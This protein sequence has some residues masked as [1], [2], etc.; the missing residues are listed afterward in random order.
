[1]DTA[2]CPP[3]RFSF[4][5]PLD[6]NIGDDSRQV[7]EIH[8]RR[9]IRGN[10]GSGRAHDSR[11]RARGARR[12]PGRLPRSGDGGRFPGSFVEESEGLVA[13]AR[14]ELREETGLADPAVHLE[15]LAT[16]GDPRRDPR[17][18][19]V[20]V[21]YLALAAELPDPLS[22]KRRV[23]SDL[24]TGCGATL[25]L[26]Q[27]CLRPRHNPC[28]RPRASPREA[29][30]LAVGD[31]VL[32]RRVHRRRAPSRVRGRLGHRARSAQLS[33]K[34]H[35]LTGVPGADR[36]ADDPQW[37]ET[38]PALRRGD[39]LV[40]TANLTPSPQELDRPQHDLDRRA[41]PGRRPQ[42]QHA[43]DR[44]SA[45]AHVLQALAGAG[46]STC[47]PV[48]SSETTTTR[49]PLRCTIETDRALRR[50]RA[51]AR[52]RG[53]PAR[54]GTP[55]SPRPGRGSRPGRSPSRR[56]A[57]R[58]RRGSRRS[59]GAPR[60]M[61]PSPTPTR[62]RAPRTAPPAAPRSTRT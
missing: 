41:L 3:L 33:P 43:L 54:S 27:A 49:R 20:S 8:F 37:R 2:G 44:G 23:R 56:R 11:W 57:R 1:M 15:Q 39:A 19:V 10:R 24:A 50:R 40:S 62:A 36:K 38:G 16:Y 47:E 12:A 21:A 29:G 28:R 25:E 31:G 14:R 53:P 18:R 32:R 4:Y 34:S 6:D 5:R 58:R 17:Q 35:R 60:R 42:R 52:S 46:S 22:G 45:R 51:C 26:R 59:A 13:A 61:E 30:V 9:G 55:R 7:D 48:P